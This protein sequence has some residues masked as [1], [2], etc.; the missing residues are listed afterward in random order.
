MRGELPLVIYHLGNFYSSHCSVERYFMSYYSRVIVEMYVTAP[1]FEASTDTSVDDQRDGSQEVM[2]RCKEEEDLFA[3]KRVLR[4]RPEQTRQLL[5][6]PKQMD[7]FKV[8]KELLKSEPVDQS[9]LS[10]DSNHGIE[11]LVKQDESRKAATQEG[12]NEYLQQEGQMCQQLQ[13]RSSSQ[14]PS[15]QPRQTTTKGPPLYQQGQRYGNGGHYQQVKQEAG[16]SFHQLSAQL[17]SVLDFSRLPS[18]EDALSPS[19]IKLNFS[20]LVGHSTW[21]VPCG[22]VMWVAM[23]V[24]PSHTSLNGP[25]SPPLPPS[26]PPLPLFS[27]CSFTNQVLKLGRTI[28]L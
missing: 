26:P 15:P 11:T 3:L 6:R 24:V 13:E 22:H 2:E 19:G 17:R 9:L 25:G 21:P 23:H 8:E 16:D 5:R 18:L 12:S 7:K 1:A 28:P 14:H 4:S 20:R 10:A 27:R